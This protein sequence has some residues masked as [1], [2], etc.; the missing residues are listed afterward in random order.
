MKRL[1]LILLVI[2]YLV[3][4]VNWYRVPKIKIEVIMENKVISSMKLC[5]D[6]E[7]GCFRDPQL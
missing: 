2:L 5:F 3:V 6:Y 7:K 4:G 1:F